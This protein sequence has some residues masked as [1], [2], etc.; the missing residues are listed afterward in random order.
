LV[1]IPAGVPLSDCKGN[2]E[3]FGTVCYFSY[4]VVLLNHEALS[5]SGGGGVEGAAEINDTITITITVIHHRCHS[6][7]LSF[8]IT[9]I[10]HHIHNFIKDYDQT[11][12]I[13]M[14]RALLEDL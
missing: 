14:G 6:P 3:Y 9:I 13:V 1:Y 5:V 11:T 12:C 7:S 8:T 10:H 4:Y 2:A